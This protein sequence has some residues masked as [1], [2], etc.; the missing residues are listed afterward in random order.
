M[1]EK[2]TKKVVKLNSHKLVTHLNTTAQLP[3]KYI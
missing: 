2:E 1:Q 3:H